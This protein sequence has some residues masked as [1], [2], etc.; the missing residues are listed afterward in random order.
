MKLPVLTWIV[1]V[2]LVIGLLAWGGTN[3]V[4]ITPKHTSSGEALIGGDFTLV[5]GQGKPVHATDFRGRYMLV[6]FG[7]THCPDIC[8]TGLLTMQN[9]LE[10]LGSKADRIAPIFITVD[11]ERDTPKVMRNYVKHFGGRI[12]GLTGSLDQVKVATEA[13]KVYFSK[14]DD[15]KSA[16]GYMVDHSAYFYLMGPDGKYIAHFPHNVSEQ[17]LTEQ[18]NSR[19]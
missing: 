1:C 18:L 2:L 10:K 8:P 9:A 16:L 5:D 6:Y 19:I 17:V 15:D 12:I 14:V 13:Y 3:F 7:F 11:P 4:T